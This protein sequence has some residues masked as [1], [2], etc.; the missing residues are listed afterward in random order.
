MRRVLL[1]PILAFGTIAGFAHGFH[2]LRHPGESGCHRWHDAEYAERLEAPTPPP[3]PVIVNAPAPA[4][5]AA[6]A[7][8][9]PAQVLV[10]PIIVG[11]GQQP[12]APTS[13]VIPVSTTNQL[14]APLPATSPQPPA[15]NPAPAAVQT[16]AAK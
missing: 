12:S 5:V 10:I 6:P 14:P 2:A 16:P 1:I 9:Q 3:A 4:P 7:P 13:Y 15:T 11:A 8:A